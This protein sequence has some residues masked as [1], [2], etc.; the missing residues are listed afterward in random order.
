MENFG[1]NLSD[2]RSILFS[3]SAYLERYSSDKAGVLNKYPAFK[4]KNH[5]NF[6][7]RT[8]TDKKYE[9]LKQNEQLD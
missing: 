8:G 1:R 3:A 5:D 6:E 7:H 4:S 9:Y 2:R